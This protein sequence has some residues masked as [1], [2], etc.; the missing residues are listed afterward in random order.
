MSLI[1]GGHILFKSTSNHR[2]QEQIQFDCEKE[3]EPIISASSCPYTPQGIIY[4]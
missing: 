3:V 1:I 4:M 2:R